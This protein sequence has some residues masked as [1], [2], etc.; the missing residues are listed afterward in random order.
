MQNPSLWLQ[1]NGYKDKNINEPYKKGQAYYFVENNKVS[2]KQI[3]DSVNEDGSCEFHSEGSPQ[4]KTLHQP[5]EAAYYRSGFTAFLNRSG[6][7]SNYPQAQGGRKS[8]RR[9]RSKKS[10]RKGRKTRR[11]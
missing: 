3:C 1:E 9:K 5:D 7:A 6:S 8:R 10:K 4:S 11:K 2:K